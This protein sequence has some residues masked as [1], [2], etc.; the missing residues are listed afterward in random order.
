MRWGMGFG[1]AGVIIGA[2]AACGTFLDVSGDDPTGAKPL[3]N[4]SP[5]GSSPDAERALGAVGV[6]TCNVG[7]DCDGGVCFPDGTCSAL[8]PPLAPCIAYWQ[9]DTGFCTPPVD[10]GDAGSLVGYCDKLASCTVPTAART[11][12]LKGGL[13]P[14]KNTPPTSNGGPVYACI[15]DSCCLGAR[16]GVPDG[17]RVRDES[18]CNSCGI[19]GMPCGPEQQCCDGYTC[20]GTKCAPN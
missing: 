4:G 1:A 11:G 17:V 14:Q 18:G 6:D 12:G 13:A 5:E 3:T 20:N 15:G 16:C 19:T 9:C 10:P 7:A 2:V 8:L